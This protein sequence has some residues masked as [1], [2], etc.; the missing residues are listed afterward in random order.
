MSKRPVGDKIEETKSITLI[1]FYHELGDM[2]FKYQDFE[3]VF[4]IGTKA[5]AIEKIKVNEEMLVIA[6]I[7]DEYYE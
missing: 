6:L 7:G 2:P 1:D 5:F 4:T 3:V